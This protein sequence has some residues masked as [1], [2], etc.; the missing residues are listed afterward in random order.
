MKDLL[1]SLFLRLSAASSGQKVVAVTFVLAAIAA[2][3]IGSWLSSRPHWEVLVS[4]LDDREFARVGEALAESGVRWRSSQPPRPFVVYVDA[5]QRTE[6]LNAI[7]VSGALAGSERGI[8]TG[9]TGMGSVF[10]YSKEREQLTRKKD[11]QDMETMLEFQE[12]IREARVRTSLHDVDLLGRGGQASASV[13]LILERGR[14][15]TRAQGKTVAD[16]VRQGLG[17][18]PENLIVSDQSGKTLY[19]GAEQANGNG[20]GG[21]WLDRA[22]EEDRQLAEEANRLLDEILGTGLARVTVRSEW[23]LDHSVQLV[24]GNDPKQRAVT[25]ESKRTSQTP[26]FPS[27]GGGGAAGTSSN[28]NTSSEFGT[29]SLGVVDLSTPRPASIEPALGKTTEEMASYS[30]TRT[31]SETIRR[32][33]KRVRMSVS[34]WLDESLAKRRDSLEQTVRATVGF[35]PNRSDQFESALV[36][37]AKP[38][39]AE[40]EEGAE[41]AP[42]GPSPMVELLLTRGVEA[43][44]ALFF[45]I[46]LALSLKRSK[47]AQ[48]A[49][50]VPTPATEAGGEG[51]EAAAAAAEEAEVEIDPELLALERVRRLVEEEPD[52]VGA[53]LTAWARGDEA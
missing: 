46:V 36:P 41:E 21:E 42:A 51:A 35:D 31:F 3:G 19:D 1:Q 2:A 9:T 29:D 47:A 23:D 24:E 39:A 48:V 33:P 49:V 11:W 30:P 28:V 45:L 7:M 25:Q 38:E 16:L 44:A 20:S 4:E 22:E 14:T 18:S 15:L 6:G 17:I 12:F 13:T 10:L 40:G 26:V 27:P 37:F 34:L 53:L 43:V 5:S 8:L 32:A 50:E 52:K